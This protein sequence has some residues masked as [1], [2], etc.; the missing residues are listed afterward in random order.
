MNYDQYLNVDGKV[1]LS[2]FPE[3]GL[4][5][6]DFDDIDFVRLCAEALIEAYVPSSLHDPRFE[7][8][9]EGRASK[10]TSFFST[11]GFLVNWLAFRLGAR[12]LPWM[13]YN[14]PE[15]PQDDYVNGANMSR[16]YNKGL[17][18]RVFI[19]FKGGASPKPYSLVFMSRGTSQSEHVCVY[20]SERYEGTKV[21]WR[22]ADA[23]QPNTKNEQSACFKERELINNRKELM[24][25]TGPK[26]VYGWIEL[27]NIPLTA[28]MHGRIAA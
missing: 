23:G 4:L 14:M 11:C 18:S 13:N 12:M 6:A 19:P 22:S 15:T 5:L 9:T 21:F 28:P 2:L 27:E 1:D 16:F 17:S 24:T 20:M 25:S 8:I 26:K 3:E 7:E 10:A